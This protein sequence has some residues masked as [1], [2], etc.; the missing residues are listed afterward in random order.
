MMRASLVS[1]LFLAGVC[2]ADPPKIDVEK[3]V[4]GSVGQWIS[5]K[6]TTDAKNIRF[7]PLDKELYQFPFS[8]VFPPE[9]TAG[10]KST[11]VQSHKAGTYRLLAYTG[12]ADGGSEPVIIRVVIEGTGPAPFPPGPNPPIPVPPGPAPVPPMPVPPAPPAPEL[13][14]LAKA[15][16]AGAAKVVLDPAAKQKT[17]KDLA[18]Y[19]ISLASTIRAGG[20]TNPQTGRY[21][22]AT[23]LNEWRAGIKATLGEAHQAWKAWSDVVSPAL[24]AEFKAQWSGR[25]MAAAFEEIGKGLSASTP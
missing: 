18:D 12:N 16:A 20:V 25:E 23:A 6:G 7:F 13:T 21:D 1:V 5:I 9:M 22:H 14:G 2:F 19:H 24:Q 4:K 17:Q 3:E 10:L 8:D 11:I 15:S